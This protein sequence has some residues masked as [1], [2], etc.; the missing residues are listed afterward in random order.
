MPA[1]KYSF[2][3]KY[4]FDMSTYFTGGDNIFKGRKPVGS[5]YYN[6]GNSIVIFG[7]SF[8]HNQYL[9]EDKTL[10][11][12]L[13]QELKRPVYN[14]AIP[15]RGVEQ[16]YLQCAS[17]IFYR[18]VPKSDMVIYIMID[19]HFRRMKVNNVGVLDIHYIDN[20]RVKNGK[21]VE[22]KNNPLINLIKSSYSVKLINQTW[23]TNYI[24]NEKNSDKLT[25]EMLL[26]FTES[27]RAMENRWNNK[28]RFIVL[29]YTNIP[30]EEKIKAKLK[31]NSFEVY[32]IPKEIAPNIE[33]MYE[34]YLISDVNF[35]PNEKAV[36]I[37]LKELIEKLNLKK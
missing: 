16:M 37:I 3:H 4:Y 28:I 10:G 34:E 20:Y 30:Y 25:D 13:S 33:L 35:H 27:R 23:A 11:Y 9:D 29:F 36:D 17:D 7:G 1:F 15:G 18:D 26:Y 21:I 6:D 24:N 32:S 14:R 22:V 31:A 19:D 12:K 5:E 8:A 2:D